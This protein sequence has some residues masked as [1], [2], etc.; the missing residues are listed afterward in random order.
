M[1]ASDSRVAQASPTIPRLSRGQGVARPSLGPLAGMTLQ[2]MPVPL[3]TGPELPARP[4]PNSGDTPIHEH[5]DSDTF[6]GTGGHVLDG[7]RLRGAVLVGRRESRRPDPERGGLPLRH[8]IH[9]RR[10][11]PPADLG[12][13][14][15]PVCAPMVQQPH[16]VRLGHHGGAHA[17]F[18]NEAPDASKVASHHH[19][20]RE[21]DHR[22]LR[23][24]HGEHPAHLSHSNPL[25]RGE[26]VPLTPEE[27]SV[28]TNSAQRHQAPLPLRSADGALLRGGNDPRTGLHAGCR[29]V[30][31][32]LPVVLPDL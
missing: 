8:G 27:A 21:R 2:I 24:P 7:H 14:R 30:P 13:G 20:S 31:V 3:K 1:K 25:G 23:G 11:Q 12:H 4:D 19:L 10:N 5:F 18:G 28:T 26:I 15:G 29:S 22:E 32:Q 16:Q 9:A 6:Q 17:H